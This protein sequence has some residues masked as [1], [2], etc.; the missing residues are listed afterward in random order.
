MSFVPITNFFCFFRRQ[1]ETI[2]FEPETG[3]HSNERSTSLSTKEFSDENLM[4][5]IDD[6]L[7]D[8]NREQVKQK[9]NCCEWS[10]NIV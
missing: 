7:G 1:I 8:E 5:E 4:R 10:E 3:I 2:G 9:K 6:F